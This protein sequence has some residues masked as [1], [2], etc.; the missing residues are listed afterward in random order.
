M[1]TCV[2]EKVR[3]FEA[4]NDL[5]LK[6]EIAVLGSTYMAEFPFYELINR[7]RL[8]N[9]VYNRSIEGLTVSEAAEILPAAVLELR[10]AKVFLCF[11]EAT[12][13]RGYGALIQQTLAALPDAAIYVVGRSK[14]EE[15]RLAPLCDGKRV[16]YVGLS[17]AG[18]Y[19]T[20][21]KR[22]CCFFR[23]RPIDMV[24]AFAMAAL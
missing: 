8:E 6:G 5:S 20:A 24:D 16:C 4:L 18:G 13:P 10:P 14:N 7:C 17:S 9:A 1:R 22:L 21:F 15:A 11:D 23:R 19:K 2:A 3:A 12:E